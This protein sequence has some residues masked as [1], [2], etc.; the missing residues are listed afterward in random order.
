MK[1]DTLRHPKLYD[2]AA[3]LDCSRAEAIGFLTLL[4]DMTSQV[5]VCGDI[6][7]WANG[8]I[9]R[10]CEWHG[11]SDVFIEALIASRW[12]DVSAEHRLIVHDS[13]AG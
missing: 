10:A 13:R 9:A 1:R 5:A 3:R 6:G 2:L 4:W 12:L 11:D 7:K 8:A